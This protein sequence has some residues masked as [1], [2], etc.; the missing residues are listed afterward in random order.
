MD[1]LLREIIADN[2]KFHI[3]ETELQRSIS[4]NES[5]FDKNFIKSLNEKEAFCFGLG[6]DA[7]EFIYNSIN[8]TSNTLEI[9]SGLSTFAFALK[10]SNHTTVTPNPCEVE[11]IKQYGK[12]KKIDLNR[13][14]FIIELSETY[15]PNS[16]LKD[17]D[18]VLIDGKH[19]FP[20]PIIDWFYCA[21]KLKQGGLMMIDDNQMSSV[22]VLTDFLKEE[23][24]RWDLI[25]SINNRTLI[26][27]KKTSS[28][29]DVAWHMQ[30]YITNRLR[31]TVFLSNIKQ[32]IASIKKV[33]HS[34]NK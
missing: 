18:F 32:V 10:K 11:S 1:S 28:V 24:Q 30:P 20:W 15:L 21:D 29:L 2:P 19:A 14:N 26:F 8:E 6:P 27:Q 22:S 13:I 5:F 23:N 9:G 4:N 25:K 12:I 3:G 7:L 16:C 31:K 34:N 17:L 33:L